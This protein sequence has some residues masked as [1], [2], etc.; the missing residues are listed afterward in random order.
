MLV[1]LIV[2]VYLP[3]QKIMAN[4]SIKAACR[5]GMT[6]RPDLKLNGGHLFSGGNILAVMN[7]W[8]KQFRRSVGIHGS[9]KK[10]SWA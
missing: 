4:K 6:I 7:F 3:F 9:W 2:D 5:K 1:K 8:Q 10:R